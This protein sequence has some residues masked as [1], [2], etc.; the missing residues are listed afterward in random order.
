MCKEKDEDGKW[1]CKKKR[2]K[3]PFNKDEIH[4][5]IRYEMVNLD[6]VCHMY[7]DIGFLL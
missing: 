3:F 5:T 1:L 6:M 2:E 4:R 7:R